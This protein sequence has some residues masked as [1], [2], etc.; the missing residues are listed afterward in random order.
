MNVEL[1]PSGGDY[2]GPLRVGMEVC[3][4]NGVAVGTISHIYQR[5]VSPTGDA[6]A[7]ATAHG[8]L[9]EVKTGLLG[10]GAHYY[11]PVGAFQESL[12]DSAFLT[13]TKGEIKELGWDRKPDLL[14]QL[15]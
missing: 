2:L 1:P 10:L 6:G 15:V 4:V 5:L 8:Q 13:K 3:D 7:A 11:I 9:V 12:R 14:E